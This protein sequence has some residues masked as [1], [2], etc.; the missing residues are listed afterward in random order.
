MQIFAKLAVEPKR[1][2][3]LP[4][5]SFTTMK[6]ILI[7]CSESDQGFWLHQSLQQRFPNWP[8]TRVNTLAGIRARMAGMAAGIVICDVALPD[9]DA[10]E[11]VTENLE[12][13]AS[14]L[15]FILL[16]DPHVA[17]D[18]QALGLDPRRFTFLAKPLEVSMF[19]HRV[20]DVWSATPDS[21]LSGI[22][23]LSFIQVLNMERKSCFLEVSTSEGQGTLSLK[24]G[25]LVY[26]AFS[27]KQG[28]E[29]F[30]SLCRAEV[31]QIRSYEG[32]VVTS[33][34]LDVSITELLLN[35]YTA[36]DE[37]LGVGQAG[38]R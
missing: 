17:D 10:L 2:T 16:C 20:S 13:T 22:P 30:Y 26:A 23:L 31:I 28:V 29:A 15:R 8:S 3:L 37:G 35:Y 11:L 25:R 7:A 14:A 27:G 36:V 19:L 1:V 6:S 9:G 5:F 4:L 34:N 33:T 12:D 32:D 24:G 18:L 21:I 38:A